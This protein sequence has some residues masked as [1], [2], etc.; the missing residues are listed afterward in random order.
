MPYY[1]YVVLCEDGSF[2][3]G[4]AKDVERRFEQHMKGLAARYTR[5]RRPVKIVYV[6]K[7]DSRGG[8]MKRERQ[9]KALSHSQKQ[10]L[11]SSWLE[12]QPLSAFP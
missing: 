3:T 6:E 9:I 4:H 10:L 7:C 5:I 11:I 8:A 12:A 1:V 2:Y